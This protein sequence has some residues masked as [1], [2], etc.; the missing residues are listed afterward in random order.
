[1]KGTAFERKYRLYVGKVSSTNSGLR[2]YP[3]PL[4]PFSLG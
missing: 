3:E 2:L 1:M 4:E